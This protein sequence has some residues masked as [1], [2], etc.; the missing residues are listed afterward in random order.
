MD[1]PTNDLDIET[2]ELLEELVMDYKGTVLLVSHD[3]EFVNNVVTSTLVF[4]EGGQ[5]SEY[6]GG[7]D[8]WLKFSTETAKQ[9]SKNS[10]AKKDGAS[11]S[12]TS[13]N[14]ISDSQKKVKKLSYNDQRELDALPKQIESYEK[15]V[16]ALQQSI[17]SDDFYKQDKEQIKEIQQKLAASQEKLSQ[18]YNRWEELE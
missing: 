15:E 4:E 2:L 3:R 8:D 13:T 6:V 10:S 1:E 5:V 7:Y 9:N 11:N 16:E 14:Q 17:A 12:Q 18:C